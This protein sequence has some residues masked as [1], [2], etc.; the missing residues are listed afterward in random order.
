MKDT[1]YIMSCVGDAASKIMSH[2]LQLVIELVLITFSLGYRDEANKS[3]NDCFLLNIELL[4]PCRKIFFKVGSVYSEG[5]CFFNKLLR[6]GS[7]GLYFIM[8]LALL[9]TWLFLLVYFWL[10]CLVSK[11]ETCPKWSWTIDTL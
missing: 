8:S 9:L 11:V 5:I 7:L 2:L 10:A 6:S 3:F 4:Q 1:P